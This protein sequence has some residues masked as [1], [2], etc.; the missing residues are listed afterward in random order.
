MGLV[1][2]EL[3][4][5]VKSKKIAVLGGAFK[6]DSDDVRDSPA[7][8]I[9]EQLRLMGGRVHLHDPKAIDG[10]KKK[11]PEII[12]SESIDEVLTG[13]KIVLHLT[14]WKVYREIDPLHARS[15]TAGAIIIDGRNMLDT[16]L[17]RS[18]GWRL[19]GLGRSQ[20]GHT[21]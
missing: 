6:P 4:G 5:D 1:A 16:E 15:L 21:L 11:Y 3:N 2:R 18:A 13:A 12:Y 17:W 19:I 8:E 20:L 7:L 9:A 10:A 14:E